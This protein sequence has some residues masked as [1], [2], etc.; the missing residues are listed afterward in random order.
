MHPCTCVHNLSVTYV[1]THMHTRTCVC[2]CVCVC[3]VVPQGV[4]ASISTTS[5]VQHVHIKL[6]PSGNFK[7]THKNT[8]THTLHK[9]L[10]EHKCEVL[11]VAM[12]L[13]IGEDML[14]K[15]SP[16]LRARCTSLKHT[17][18]Y[19]FCVQNEIN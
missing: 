5:L 8:R 13:S 1:Y 10:C 12:S 17:K 19:A 7:R 15:T 9:K 2:V 14:T 3:V 6:T 18:M 16:T 4:S 11:H